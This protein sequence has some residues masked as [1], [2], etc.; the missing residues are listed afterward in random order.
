[1]I[2]ALL[3]QGLVCGTVCQLV[4]GRSLASDS[5]GDILKI[6]YLGFEK[7]QRS[8]MHDFLCYINILTYLL[9]YCWM[10]DKQ[11]VWPVKTRSRYPKNFLFRKKWRK[12]RG[13]RLENGHQNLGYLEEFTSAA[14]NKNFAG[15]SPAMGS[16]TSMF[17]VVQIFFKLFSVCTLE[18]SDCR[19]RK[20]KTGLVCHGILIL[21]FS[22]FTRLASLPWHLVLSVARQHSTNITTNIESIYQKQP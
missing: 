6:I 8:V 20:F 2:E 22:N 4:C 1:M 14:A 13:G 10:D 7:S 3:L 5:L 19:H 11:N 16:R 15:R 17:T 12:M 9:T 18:S 21:L